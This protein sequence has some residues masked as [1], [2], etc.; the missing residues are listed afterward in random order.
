MFWTT[1]RNLR[2][3][4]LKSFVSNFVPVISHVDS[5]WL[6]TG[7]SEGGVCF[8]SDFSSWQVFREYVLLTTKA[9]QTEE[10]A[11]Q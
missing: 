3:E 1:D 4:V 11:A 6:H 7:L 5:E 2:S 8:L 10:G 9:R